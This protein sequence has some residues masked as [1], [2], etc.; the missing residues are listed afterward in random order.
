MWTQKD[1]YLF[2]KNTLGLDFNE[3]ELNEILEYLKQHNLSPSSTHGNCNVAFTPLKL[4]N[5][6]NFALERTRGNLKDHRF[7]KVSEEILPTIYFTLLLKKF[8]YGPHLIVSSDSPDIALVPFQNLKNRRGNKIDAFPLEAI[9]LPP[10]AINN[11]EGK[12]YPEKIA[13]LIIKKKFSKRY[14]PQTIL[15]ATLNAP[16]EDLNFTELSNLLLKN[17]AQP[18]HQVWMFCSLGPK[19]ILLVKLCPTLQNHNLNIQADLFP[20]FY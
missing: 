2:F 12:S 9:F 19:N 1:C 3:E 4:K 13:N 18:F 10:N 16:I 20:L 8:G 11:S 7:K 6:I 5:L 17:E 14:E 15:L